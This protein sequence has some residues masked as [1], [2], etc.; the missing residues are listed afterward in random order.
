[1]KT[2]IPAALGLILAAACL[3]AERQEQAPDIAFDRELT[4][5]EGAADRDSRVE[6][7]KKALSLRPNDPRNIVIEYQM[8]VALSQTSDPKHGESPRRKEGLA[9][10]S[11]IVATYDHMVYYEKVPMNATGSPQLMVPRA[12]IHAASIE[13][14]LNSNNDKARDYLWKA[15]DCLKRTFEQRKSDWLA[16]PKPKPI[17]RG[18]GDLFDSINPDAPVQAWTERHRR[19]EQGDVLGSS[20]M[21]IVRAAVRQFGYTYGRQKPEDVPIAMNEIIKKYPET[22]MARVSREHIDRAVKMVEDDLLDRLPKEAFA[23]EPRSELA[24]E[25]GKEHD[26]GANPPAPSAADT[27]TPRKMIGQGA[28]WPVIAVAAGILA[29][30][31]FLAILILRRCRGTNCTHSPKPGV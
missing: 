23:V 26:A 31:A 19:A 21:T 3:G 17:P 18:V 14:G 29:A 10:Y 5:A 16:E 7:W 4:A 28:R 22:P 13:R 2:Q 12:C 9:I 1:M 8:A 6:H 30:A 24:P 15:M 20:E 27:G 11:R 25:N